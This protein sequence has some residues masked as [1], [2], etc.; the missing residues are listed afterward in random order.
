M[1]QQNLIEVNIPGADLAEIQA[2]IGV[3]KTKLTPHLKTLTVQDKKEMA[4]MGDKSFALVQ[5][6][7][8]YSQ[9]NPSLVPG[10]LDLTAF[11]KDVAAV[12]LLRGLQQDLGA[13]AEAVDDSLTLAGGEALQATLMFYNSAKQGAKANIPNAAP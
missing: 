12:N 11:A 2:A 10:F 4:K 7:L 8:E 9:K 3:L 5:K 13:I 1:A 6:G